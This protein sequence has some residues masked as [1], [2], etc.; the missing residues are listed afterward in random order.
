MKHWT[1]AL[2][3]LGAC[4][5]AVDWAKDFNSI[6]DAWKACERGDHMLW[7]VGKLSGK[8]GGRKRKRLVLA[9]CG[10]ARLSLKYI[11]KS[12]KQPLRAIQTAEAWANGRRGITL[13]DVII[14]AD[15]DDAAY[16]ANA[17]YA[18]N[19]ANAAANAAYAAYVAA[20][21]AYDAS[22]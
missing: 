5:E 14:A 19:V 6:E 1:T 4:E 11:P 10:C 2:V 8:P 21:D 13:D 9:A 7:L 12:E 18:A 3:K 20:Y 16:V 22:S 15:A 17:A